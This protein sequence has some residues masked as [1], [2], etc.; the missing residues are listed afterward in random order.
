[1]PA[2]IQWWTQ[3]LA[4]LSPTAL[5]DAVYAAGADLL[6]RW[7]QPHRRYHGTRHLVEVFWALEELED[8]GEI[9]S[10][11]GLLG[12]VAA[13]WHDA[14]YDPRAVGEANETDSAALSREV[15]TGLDCDADDVDT[16]ETLVLATA[17]H[18]DA[19]G[20][21][22]RAFL[23]ADLWILSA[24]TGRFDDYCGQVRAEYAHVP[25]AAYAAARSSILG[26][27]AARPHL[28]RTDHARREWEPQARINLDR[29]LA[30]LAG[31]TLDVT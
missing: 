1:M 22:E 15:L 29:E 26:E 20:S 3:D 5:D 4:A 25:D 12:R 9:D 16:I 31:P 28:Y 27:F 24:P 10:A 30:R 21:L 6:A 8:A 18:R 7:G 17:S 19:S 2:L 11:A 13:W 14:I 23:D